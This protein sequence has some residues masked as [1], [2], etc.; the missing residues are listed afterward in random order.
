MIHKKE[1]PPP[2]SSDQEA[3]RAGSEFPGGESTH[4][5]RTADQKPAR[6]ILLTELELGAALLSGGRVYV[7]PR[8]VE[9]TFDGLFTGTGLDPRTTNIE[10]QQALVGARARHLHWLEYIHDVLVVI[11]GA[12]I[13]MLEDLPASFGDGRL[14]EATL[15]WDGRRM[16]IVLPGPECFPPPA[17]KRGVSC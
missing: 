17:F 14:V 4:N 12:N 6:E 10:L 8:G 2:P 9:F 7:A 1:R 11:F 3:R 5:S 16:P 13:P 15:R